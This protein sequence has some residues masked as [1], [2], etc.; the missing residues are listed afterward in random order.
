MKKM[1]KESEKNGGP[2]EGVTNITPAQCGKWQG[3]ISNFQKFKK[4]KEIFHEILPQKK[5]KTF[6]LHSH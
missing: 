1:K 2:G 3:Q 6:T 4:K 5:K